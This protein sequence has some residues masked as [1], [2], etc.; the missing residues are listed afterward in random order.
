MD[1]V[2]ALSSCGGAARQ[3]RLK[4]LV[5]RR[6]LA[7][8]VRAG[9]VL[10]PGKGLYSLPD[11]PRDVLA[12]AAV[13]GVRSCQSAAAAYG[14]D[15]VEPP[16]EP[17]VTTRRGSKQE[18]PRTVVHHRDVVDLEGLTDPLTTVLDCLT[19]LPRR[20]AL[21]PAD[22]ALRRGLLTVE[23]LELA[24]KGMNRSDPRRALLARAD[25]ECGSALE[26]V[27]RMDLLDEGY[28]LRTQ[29]FLSPAGR[30][31]FLIDDWLVVEVDGYEY[32]AGRGP[33]AED[34][35]R[36]AELERR[37]FVVLRFTW[38]Q[39]LHDREWYLAVVQDTWA[40]GPR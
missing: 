3:A 22:S 13:S 37:G 39:I 18:W 8:A 17:H 35:R 24:A 19:C 4:H 15:L 2:D 32:H 30:V 21:A 25:P 1:A 12:A 20:C 33:F 29:E 36:D 5:P 28:D 31:D 14:L 34:R 9:E 10:T 27:A 6:A 38:A 11:C 16:V 40:R 26:S 7:A 23:D